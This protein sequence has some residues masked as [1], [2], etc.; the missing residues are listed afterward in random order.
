MEHPPAE[1]PPG[2]NR[3]LRWIFAG[4]TVWGTFLAIGAW[5]LNHDFR[6]PLIVLGC[7]AAFLGFWFVL[8]LR[9]RRRGR[10]VR[11]DAA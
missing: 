11:R 7:V 3:L 2:A 1:T 4:I 10:P 6:R 5:T 9:L 8:L